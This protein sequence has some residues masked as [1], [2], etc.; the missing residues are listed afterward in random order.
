MLRNTL[1]A[2]GWPAKLQH[3]LLALLIIGML[4]LGLV[5]DDFK[6]D[7]RFALYGIHKAIGAIILALVVVRLLWRWSNIN[8]ALPEDTTPLTRLAARGGHFLLY[9]AMLVMPLS[10]WTLSNAAGYPVSVFGWFA[11]PAIAAKNHDLH[12]LAEEVHE[13]AAYG[14]IA[15]IM[16]HIAAALYHHIIRKDAVLTR[17]LPGR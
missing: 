12:E 5:M 13:W 17:M 11:L 1:T 9:V 2:Y 7:T 10:G 14:L 8:P 4:A 15:L 6:G 3:W 16:V